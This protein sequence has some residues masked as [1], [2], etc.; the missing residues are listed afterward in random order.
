MKLMVS[1]LLA[2]LFTF[3]HRRDEKVNKEMDV[4]GVDDGCER[5]RN[6]HKKKERTG[7]RKRSKSLK[8]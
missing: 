5:E 8:V 2:Y 7:S 1:F 6:T 4:G 3:V